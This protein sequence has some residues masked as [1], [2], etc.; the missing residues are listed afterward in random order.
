[1]RRCWPL[2]LLAVTLLPSA[3]AG[4]E[5]LT[6][7]QRIE[8]IRGLTAEYAT[9]KVGLPRSKKTLELDTK[10]AYDKGTWDAA[11]REFGPAARPGDLVQVSRI[12]IEGDKIVLQINGGFNAGKRKWYQRV[13]VGT[14]T[15]TVPLSQGDSNAPGGTSIALLFHKSVPPLKA[16]EIKKMLAPVLDFE[17]HSATETAIESLPPE[18]QAAVKEKRAMEGMDRDQVLLALGR[19]VRKVRQVKEGEETEDWI[20]GTAPGRIVFVTFKDNK[21]IKVK[22]TY[23]GLGSEAPRREAPDR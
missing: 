19:P 2:A 21:A 14:G 4:S 9:A 18:F 15:R 13:E 16:A 7:E 12:E 20:Y 6:D 11:G 10:G 17:K 8:L 1:M 5:K 23:A 3:R 22:E